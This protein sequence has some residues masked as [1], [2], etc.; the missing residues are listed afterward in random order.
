[1]ER[2]SKITTT[3]NEKSHKIKSN[4]QNANDAT[5]LDAQCSIKRIDHSNA[6]SRVSR[7]IDVLHSNTEYAVACVRNRT[8]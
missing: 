7:P 1:M 2:K 8:E 6:L 5:M 3:K 4:A